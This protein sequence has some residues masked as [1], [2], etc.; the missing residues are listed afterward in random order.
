MTIEERTND[1]MCLPMVVL[2]RTYEELMQSVPDRP[3]ETGGIIGGIN[4]TVMTYEPDLGLVTRCR[5]S[6]RPDTARL[7]SII[8]SWE[9]EGICFLGIY[10]THFYGVETLSNGDIQYIGSI[11]MALRD[12]LKRLF[13]PIVVMPQK[14]IVAYEA[15]LAENGLRVVRIQLKQE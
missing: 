12:Q 1:S 3:P 6:Y 9:L 7:N 13:F 11:M 5:C 10:H 2:K 15:E 4:R 8:R 14:E